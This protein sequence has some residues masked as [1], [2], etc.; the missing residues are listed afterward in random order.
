[1]LKGKKNAREKREEEKKKRLDKLAEKIKQKDSGLVVVDDAL[2]LP[3]EDLQSNYEI[4]ETRQLTRKHFESDRE[5]IKAEKSSLQ[6]EIESMTQRE[7]KEIPDFLTDPDMAEERKAVMSK[8]K[9]LL[10]HR[11]SLITIADILETNDYD[12]LDEIIERKD[13]IYKL[14]E[15]YSGKEGQKPIKLFAGLKKTVGDEYSKL[16]SEQEARMKAAIDHIY[17]GKYFKSKEDPELMVEDIIAKIIDHPDFSLACQIEAEFMTHE[18]DRA[19]SV[20]SDLDL[21]AET[22]SLID[23]LRAISLSIEQRA[24]SYQT[25]NELMSNYIG[26]IISEDEKTSKNQNTEEIR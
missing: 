17:D 20:I 6:K 3:D 16:Y 5:F 7:I 2:S 19:I 8:I 9:T 13:N 1:M 14:V 24:H 25:V 11:F 22:A 21:R 18:L 15:K 12:S 26:N 23:E 10:S 4:A